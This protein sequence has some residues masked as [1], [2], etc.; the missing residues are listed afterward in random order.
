MAVT[1]P[2]Q[3]EITPRPRRG[4]I[5]LGMMHARIMHARFGA[6]PYVLRHKLWYLH[7]PLSSLGAL[8][9]AL[10][11]YNRRAL[12]SLRD[13][14]YGHGTTG[15][16]AWV[17]SAFLQ[18]G[19]AVPRGEIVLLTLPRVFGLAFNPVS[20]WL[21]H[22][23]AARLVAVL[24]EVNNTFGDRH[25][26]LV[27]HEDGHPISRA[28]RLSGEKVFHVSPFLPVD[29]AYAFRFVEDGDRLS[30]QIDLIRHGGRALTAT[31]NGRLAPL[32][33]RAL[34]LAL[35]RH[36]FPAGKVLGFIHMHAARLWMRGIR[37]FSR[38]EPPETFVTLAS[39]SLKPK[40][41]EAA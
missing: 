2:A 14:D 19:A 17:E 28:D 13:G 39:T 15:L 32:T 25:A 23:E 21:C 30:I 35:A 22:D 37:V 33:K 8:D 24:A 3:Q 27:R 9:S 7:V 10:I 1:G 26:Y 5:P 6:K 4:S 12:V 40:S 18:A 41:G 36:P 29:G 16:R 31:I 20:F 38:P 11:G 34:G